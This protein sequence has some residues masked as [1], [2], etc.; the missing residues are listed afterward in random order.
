M[1]PV[2]LLLLI[3]GWIGNSAA[4][5]TAL[6]RCRVLTESSARLICYDAIP[7]ALTRDA[8]VQG[9]A[10]PLASNFG[11]ES[12]SVASLAVAS[13][14]SAIEGP[15]D[16]WLPRSQLKLA[17][18]QIWEINDGSQAA[19]DLLSPRVRVSRGV[20]GSFFMAI[21][22]VSQTPRVRRIR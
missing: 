19:Y 11:L 15:F 13:I 8:A 2:L 17:N 7:L 18:G 9:A 12:R 4:D 1:K 14:E 10:T 21:Q 3:G 16:G 5:D 6:A 22:G 20:S